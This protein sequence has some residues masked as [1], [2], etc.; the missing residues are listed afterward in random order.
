MTKL[1]L[2]LNSILFNTWDETIF[3]AKFEIEQF[4]EQNIRKLVMLVNI[5]KVRIFIYISK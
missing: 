5:V 2:Q 4:L 3:N 1:G